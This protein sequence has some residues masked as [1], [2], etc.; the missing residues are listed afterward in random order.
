MADQTDSGPVR[1]DFLDFPTAWRITNEGVDHTSPR[2]SYV[3]TEGALLCD[4]GAIQTEWERR[5]AQQKEADRG[6]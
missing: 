5:V 2:C 3:Q 4:C 1:E 6:A